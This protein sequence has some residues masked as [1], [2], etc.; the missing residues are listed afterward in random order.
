MTTAFDLTLPAN[1]PLSGATARNQP[2][3]RLAKSNPITAYDLLTHLELG[4][5]PKACPCKRASVSI[6]KSL[7]QAR[8]RLELSPHLGFHIAEADLTASHG[9]IS[10]PQQNSGH[11]DW[12]PYV[13]M[14]RPTDFKVVYP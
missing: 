1:C 10:A 5:A 2:A 8:H 6:F 12:W 3:Y 11:M 4:L 13:G 7:E 14:R 9:Q